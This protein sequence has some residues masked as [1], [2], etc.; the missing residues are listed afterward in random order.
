[1][2]TWLTLN[3]PGSQANIV[4]TE[5]ADGGLLCLQEDGHLFRVAA[6]DSTARIVRLILEDDQD[7]WELI[8]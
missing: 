8:T 4:W 5:L 1:M 2:R 7:D 3:P 6:N